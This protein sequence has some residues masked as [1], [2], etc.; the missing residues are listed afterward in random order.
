MGRKRGGKRRGGE[1]EEGKRRGRRRGGEERGGEEKEQ[2]KE[3]GKRVH[4][5]TTSLTYLMKSSLS[6]VN[7][8]LY[9]SLSLAGGG[10][11]WQSVNK[12]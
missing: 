8:S 7:S 1:G 5:H 3:T 9:I 2:M 10:G 12:I 11:R 4:L 6:L